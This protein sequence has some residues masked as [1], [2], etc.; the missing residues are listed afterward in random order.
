MEMSG[1]GLGGDSKFMSVNGHVDAVQ[2]RL[3]SVNE[4]IFEIENSAA[5]GAEQAELVALAE[6]ILRGDASRL[7]QWL[8]SQDRLNRLLQERR[9]LNLAME[10]G[11]DRLQEMEGAE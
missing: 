11:L 9:I 10:R 2:K 7:A 3:D 5:A 1:E 4:R 8:D 6:E